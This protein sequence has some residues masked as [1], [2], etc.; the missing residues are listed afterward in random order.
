MKEVTSKGIVRV[1]ESELL[2]LKD[3]LKDM[4]LDVVAMSFVRSG[5]S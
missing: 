1:N 5:W 2:E 3:E 4:I